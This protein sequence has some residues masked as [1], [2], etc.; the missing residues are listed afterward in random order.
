M[1]TTTMKAEN[2]L[3]TA[4]VRPY[5][6]KQLEKRI[7][8]VGVSGVTSSRVEGFGKH[9]TFMIDTVNHIKL[10]ICV[11]KGK[12]DQVISV[13]KAEHEDESHGHGVVF[14]SPVQEMIHL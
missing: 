9:G 11:D 6:K 13:L 8:E 12:V 3:V 7:S 2:Y 10:E 14:V 1:S 4:I 5:K